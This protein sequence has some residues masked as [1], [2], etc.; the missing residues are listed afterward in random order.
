MATS[1]ESHQRLEPLQID[2]LG[3]QPEAYT[4]GD[5]KTKNPPRRGC[6]GVFVW[7]WRNCPKA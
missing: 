6:A 2:P 7:P 4:A 5:M 1:S 3:D